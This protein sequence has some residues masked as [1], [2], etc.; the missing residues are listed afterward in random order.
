MPLVL[1]LV[2]LCSRLSVVLCV[3]SGLVELLNRAQCSRADD[4]RGLL[5]KEQLEIPQFLQL[6]AGGAEDQE[7]AL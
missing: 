2:V 1:V 4:Q 6:P 3:S 5:T 7:C